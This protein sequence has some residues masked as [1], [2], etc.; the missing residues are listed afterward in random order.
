[1]SWLYFLQS[2]V[3]PVGFIVTQFPLPGTIVDVWRLL[4]DHDSD[5]IISLGAVDNAQQVIYFFTFVSVCLKCKC[6]DLIT[7]WKFIQRTEA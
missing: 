6:I 3:K 4:Y 7:S 5:V 2:F 1:M